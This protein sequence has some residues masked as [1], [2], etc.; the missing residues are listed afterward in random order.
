MRV[1][2][3]CPI[4]LSIALLALPH[5]S[6]RAQTCAP[7]TLIP[8]LPFLHETGLWAREVGMGNAH[9]AVGTDVSSIHDNPAGLAL[10]G[11]KLLPFHS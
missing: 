10:V 3:S 2:R 9:V 4:I 1:V 6:V 8:D 11:A 5:R 7:D